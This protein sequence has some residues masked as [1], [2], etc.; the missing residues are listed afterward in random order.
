M[1]IS[2]IASPLQDLENYLE[3][4]VF[5]VIGNFK[6]ELSQF[7][8]KSPLNFI[9]LGNDFH[10]FFG[11]FYHTKLLTQYVTNIITDSVFSLHRLHVASLQEG[12][13]I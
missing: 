10:E 7:K 3:K 12:E 8:F 1:E 13:Y 6:E 5:S 2:F 11:M 9:M 4:F